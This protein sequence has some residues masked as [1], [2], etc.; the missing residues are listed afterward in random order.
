MHVTDHSGLGPQCTMM[1]GENSRP[2]ETHPIEEI[3][4]KTF[5]IPAAFHAALSYVCLHRA[6]HTREDLSVTA[7]YH[8]MEALSLV[9]KQ[10]DNPQ[11]A[12]GDAAIYSV[13]WL[14]TLEVKM[15]LLL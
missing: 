14:L 5:H 11:L 10:L 9:N 8:K 1:F 12:T 4:G 2:V 13:I 6:Y 3:H 7:T 15:C